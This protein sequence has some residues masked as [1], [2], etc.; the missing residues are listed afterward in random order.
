MTKK[1]DRSSIDTFEQLDKNY[2]M[3]VKRMQNFEWQIKEGNFPKNTMN[4]WFKELKQ[5]VWLL[6][7]EIK[8]LKGTIE[9][10]EKSWKKILKEQAAMTIWHLKLNLQKLIIIKS[11]L[12]STI[13]QWKILEKWGSISA[14]SK[15]SADTLWIYKELSEKFLKLYNS[16]IR[17][18]NKHISVELDNDYE[19]KIEKN[20]GFLWIEVDY[21]TSMTNMLEKIDLTYKQKNNICRWVLKPLQKTWN[22]QR[23]SDNY[24]ISWDIHKS[25]FK[26]DYDLWLKKSQKRFSAAKNIQ[27]TFVLLDQLLHYKESKNHAKQL[28]ASCLLE[29]EKYDIHIISRAIK[30]IVSIDD[31]KSTLGYFQQKEELLQ[32]FQY[33]GKFALSEINMIIRDYQLLV[34]NSRPSHMSALKAERLS[35]QENLNKIT[36][37][38]K[39]I[40]SYKYLPFDSLESAISKTVKLKQSRG[41]RWYIRADLISKLE[42]KYTKQYEY[43]I[44]QVWS[45]T[46]GGR[47]QVSGWSD[48]LWDIFSNIS[49]GSS[50]W[51]WGGRSIWGWSS[52]GWWGW[53]SSGGTSW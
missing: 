48:I 25:K 32:P 11:Q 20:D 45:L 42:K 29:L 2:G 9:K 41:E 5:Y 47:R 31:L 13:E 1:F 27:E 43:L 8:K 16:Y 3:L 38:L 6:D 44:S 39:N 15:I 49:S 37:T 22:N 12:E 53:S 28:L 52:F 18:N 10:K 26:V 33:S 36:S 24:V 34:E 51:G 14:T 21:L 4:V 40:S 50:R 30:Q 35:I 46:S 17:L 19:A 23:T 7:R